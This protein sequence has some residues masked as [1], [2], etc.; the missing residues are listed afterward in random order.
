MN[1]DGTET[2][3]SK[4][5]RLT[6]PSIEEVLSGAGTLKG[7]INPEDMSLRTEDGEPIFVPWST[8]I[9]AEKDGVIRGGAILEEGDENGPAFSCDGIGFTGYLLGQPYQGEYTRRDIDP[10]DVVR[11]LWQHKQSQPG[12]NIGLQVDTTTSPV[13]IGNDVEPGKENEGPKPYVLAWWKDYDMGQIVDGLAAATPFDYRVVHEWDGEI[14]RHR[15]QLGYPTIGSRRRDLSFDVGI[16]IFT[17]PPI[18]YDGGAYASQVVVLGAGEGR[19][20]VRGEAVRQTGRLHRTV[21]VDEK[22]LTRKAEADKA[23][24]RELAVRLGE[25]DI[26]TFTVVDHPNA[27]LG[28]FSPG[29]EIMVRTRPGWGN[30]RNLWV[31]ILSVSISPETDTATLAVRRVEKMDNS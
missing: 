9:Y 2:F 21:V 8:V 14:I 15:L 11:H 13:R 17:Q 22:D 4:D 3:L 30:A 10:L 16:N 19:A 23:A 26:D 24:A 18:S 31:R 1:G 5:V 12:G 25:P 27:L 20:M 7:T 6:G 29:D 28:S